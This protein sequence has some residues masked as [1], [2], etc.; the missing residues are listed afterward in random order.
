MAKEKNNLYEE[1]M[2][3]LLMREKLYPFNDSKNYKLY[4]G[5]YSLLDM[6]WRMSE[7]YRFGFLVDFDP[8]LYS[9]RFRQYYDIMRIRRKLTPKWYQRIRL[10][11]ITESSLPVLTMTYSEEDYNIKGS[12]RNQ[13][14]NLTEKHTTLNSLPLTLRKHPPNWSQYK[15]T[16][17]PPT[18]SE[19]ATLRLDEEVYENGIIKYRDELRKYSTD[20]ARIINHEQIPKLESDSIDINDNSTDYNN[21]VNNVR[22]E[23]IKKELK[24]NDLPGQYAAEQN[25]MFK[26]ILG[27]VSMEIRAAV[28]LELNKRKF[29]GSE[30]RFADKSIL[31]KPPTPKELFTGKDMTQAATI[32]H[33]ILVNIAKYDFNVAESFSFI[34]SVLSEDALVWFNNL[35][36]D[37]FNQNIEN[38]LYRFVQLFKEQY[39]NQAMEHYMNI[40]KV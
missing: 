6:D 26:H 15:M 11:S 39:M 33:Y 18:F 32:L 37:I 27:E 23:F 22:Q 7:V 17:N 14:F 19:L 12:T 40:K 31:K 28:I 34:E 38:Q 4:A 30:N 2:P 36:A 3:F 13:D 1:L 16:H 5:R 8:N 10:N 21:N 35:Y 25:Y 24:R 29:T 20:R 9:S